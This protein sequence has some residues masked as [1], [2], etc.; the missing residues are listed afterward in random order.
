MDGKVPCGRFL[1]SL[2][3]GCGV[4]AKDY[5]SDSDESGDGLFHLGLSY[6]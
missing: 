5:G 1:H 3:E 4:R 6:G 2:V